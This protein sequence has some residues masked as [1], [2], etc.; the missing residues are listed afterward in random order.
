MIEYSLEW[1]LK[2]AEAIIYKWG[3][4]WMMGDVDNIGLVSYY[5]MVADQ[6]YDPS[7]GAKRST[8]RV[9]R[10]IYAIK[11]IRANRKRKGNREVSLNSIVGDSS[12]GKVTEIGALIPSKETKEKVSVSDIASRSSLTE[13]QSRYVE[14][15][16]SGKKMVDIAKEEGICKQAVSYVISSAVEKMRRKVKYE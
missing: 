11:T 4:A 5:M 7:K 3:D 2:Q 10:G 13:K 1:Y 16:L 6:K 12:S 8:W 14:K 9:L 15:Y